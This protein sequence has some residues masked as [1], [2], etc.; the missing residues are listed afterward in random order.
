ML[1]NPWDM[2]MTKGP[3]KTIAC[4][5]ASILAADIAGYS[6]LMG[7]QDAATVTIQDTPMPVPTLS[8]FRGSQIPGA[9]RPC[10]RV[11]A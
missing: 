6:A 10:A 1:T 5:L 11:R 3:E 2:E 7:D 9:R 4:K 8:T